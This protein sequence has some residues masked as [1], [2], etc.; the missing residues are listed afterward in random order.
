MIDTVFVFF[1][2]ERIVKV[3]VNLARCQT[4]VFSIASA[5]V[6]FLVVAFLACYESSFR[7][8]VSTV[9]GNPH[10]IGPRFE[11]FK[12]IEFEHFTAV[13]DVTLA[14]LL[15]I[16]A[17]QIVHV[18]VSANVQWTLSVRIVAG[19]KSF[20]RDLSFECGPSEVTICK[21]K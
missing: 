15:A 16:L 4:V 10:H 13:A 11:Y 18:L 6:Q 19:Y 20:F 17:G 9:S 21:A 5:Q 2:S 8:S 12:I 1:F 3:F 14:Q 7:Q